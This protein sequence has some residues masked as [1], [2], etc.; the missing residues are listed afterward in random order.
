MLLHLSDLHFGTH[1]ENCITAIQNFCRENKVEVVVVSGDLT[2]R[3]RFKE[4]FHCKLFL[5]S[6]NLPYLVVPGNHDIPLYHVWRRMFS[7]FVRYQNFFGAPEQV[8]ETQNFYIVG[9]N[10]IHRRHHTKGRLSKKQINNIAQK[11]EQAPENKIK[12]VV[13][14]QPFYAS[15]DAKHDMKD[16]PALAKT[17]LQIWGQHGLFGLLHGHLHQNAVY[18]LNKI[19]DLAL[20]LP[21]YDIHAGTSTSYRL[22][23]QEPNSFNVLFADKKITHFEFNE[24]SQEFEQKEVFF[25]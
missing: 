25:G 24:D 8:L 1:K 2:Q 19:Y 21:V 22:H 20:D 23:E 12:L 15:A 14:H 9:V 6:L 3:A 5:E 17:A 13:I 7:P 10:S 16:C 11:I 4:F 18:D